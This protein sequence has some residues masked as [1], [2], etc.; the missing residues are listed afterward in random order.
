[1]LG[2]SDSCASR[3]R[4]LETGNF[5]STAGGT[6]RDIDTE[7][8]E[9]ARVFTYVHGETFTIAFSVRNGG[10]FPVTVERLDNLPTEDQ[11]FPMVAEEVLLGAY[12]DDWNFGYVPDAPFNAFSLEPG[13]QRVIGVRAR[14]AHCGRNAEGTSTSWEVAFVRFRAFGLTHTMEVPLPLTVEVES[15]DRADCPEPTSSANG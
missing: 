10:R 11:G 7:D 6:F 5:F 3:Y 1:M 15:P 12:E 14:F 13:Q 2:P 4:P 9:E 8:D